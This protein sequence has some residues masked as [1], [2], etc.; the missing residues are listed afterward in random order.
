VQPLPPSA[1]CLPPTPLPPQWSGIPLLTT[2]SN[3]GLV[4]SL[5]ALVWAVASRPLGL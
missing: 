5:V 1:A 3:A 4:A 2:I